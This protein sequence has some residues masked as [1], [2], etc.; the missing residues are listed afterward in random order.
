MQPLLS[1]F[2]LMLQSFYIVVHI[3][4]SMVTYTQQFFIS[5]SRHDFALD[6]Q[7]LFIL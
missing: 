6:P 2:S 1:D 5:S 3:H 7:A 4:F